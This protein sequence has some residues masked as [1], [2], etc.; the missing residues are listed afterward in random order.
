M[1]LS[2]YWGLE[3]IG[4]RYT[5]IPYGCSEKIP[6]G[7]AV[8]SSFNIWCGVHRMNDYWG[9]GGVVDGHKYSFHRFDSAKAL[10]LWRAEG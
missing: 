7:L 4:G 2:K 9:A 8:N 3:A 1:K 6:C 10:H 5:V